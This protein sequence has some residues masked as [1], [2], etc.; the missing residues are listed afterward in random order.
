MFQVLLQIF[1]KKTLRNPPPFLRV[2]A[3]MAALLLYGTTGFLYFELP[4]NPDLTWWDAFWYTVV[5]LTTVG[6]GDFFPKTPG[7][8]FLV[9]GPIMVFGIGLL[10]YA[11][12]LI[13]S[14]LVTSQTKELKGM[15]AF[16]LKKHLVLFNFAGTAKVERILDE[17]NEDP[18]IGKIPVVLVDELLEELPA[19]LQKRGVHYVRGNPSR[20]ETLKR[21]SIEQASHAVI[22]TRNATDPASDHLNLAI[23]LAIEGLCKQVNTVVEC[24]SPSSEELLRKAGSD[25]I[26][27][28][29][30]FD[31]YLL[32]QE[33]L[34]PGIQEVLSELLTVTKGQQFNLI[35]IKNA[36]SFAELAQRALVQGHVALGVNYADK[37]L[38]LNPPS[39]LAVP[40]GAYVIT[41][42]PERL[43]SL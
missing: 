18:A 11:L 26:V 42:G 29:H 14:A 20:D 28:S 1:N 40:V 41:M 36:G 31:A 7:G 17:L 5:T 16:K 4:N 33:L 13:A 32:S 35:P 24:L 39:H 15:S 22:L 21:A 19:E 9:G 8:R 10:G 37:T 30:R 27:C 3:L 23:V 6:Y 43:E 12:S 2:S 38:A 34:N 25:R